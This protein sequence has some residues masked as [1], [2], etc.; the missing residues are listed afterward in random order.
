MMRGISFGYLH[1]H[2]GIQA[3][4]DPPRGRFE[5]E[6]RS[7]AQP[8]LFPA[9]ALE[10]KADT[11]YLLCSSTGM[12]RVLRVATG[13]RNLTSLPVGPSS[14]TSPHQTPW[15]KNPSHTESLP[16][17]PFS[18]LPSRSSHPHFES[19][20]FQCNTMFFCFFFSIMMNF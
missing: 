7:S 16:I 5:N 12:N 20:L 19:V 17:S 2:P 4:G 1:G 10:L 15:D 8:T 18:L 9:P 6:A 13:T 11:L 3:W 14:A